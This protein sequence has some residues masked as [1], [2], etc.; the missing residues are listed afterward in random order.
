[1]PIL[2]KAFIEEF[3]YVSSLILLLLQLLL[4]NLHSFF[5]NLHITAADIEEFT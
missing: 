5:F 4:K 3:T 2:I 1:M